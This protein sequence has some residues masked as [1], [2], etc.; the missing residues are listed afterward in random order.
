M[1]LDSRQIRT[2]SREP[3]PAAGRRPDVTARP[4]RN[5]TR[6][7]IMTAA[8]VA[9]L[10][11]VATTTVYEWARSGTIPALR[12]GRVIRFRRWEIEAWIAGELDRPDID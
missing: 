5:L 11:T 1:A 6:T 2:A 4:G 3:G 7:D 9:E 8:E 10:L 12:R